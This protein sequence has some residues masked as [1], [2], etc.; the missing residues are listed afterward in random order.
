MFNPLKKLY[1]KNNL[2]NSNYDEINTYDKSPSYF[3]TPKET[4]SILGISTSTLAN[5]RYANKG[6]TYI[7]VGN[8]IRYRKL[9]IDNWTNQYIQNSNPF[10]TK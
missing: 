1:R 5:W 2:K 10:D 8:L 3:F 4:A 9:D 7:K 6:P